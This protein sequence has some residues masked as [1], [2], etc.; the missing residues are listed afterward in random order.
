MNTKKITTALIT[1]ATSASL[2]AGVAIVPTTYAD[3]TSTANTAGLKSGANAAARLAKI[4]ARS[5]TAITARIAD[6]NK[7]NT[8]VQGLKNVSSTE[9]T[10]ISNDVQTNISG[11]TSL[12]AKI[13]AD[14]DATAA[15]NDEKTITG[16]FRIYA[17]V[18]PQGSILA[19]V[20]RVNTIVD[21]MTPI[22][23]KI[24]SRITA[25]QTAGKDVSALQTLLS[26][27]NS[28]IADAKIQAVAAQSGVVSLVP[29]QGNKTTLAS[30]TA[31]LKAARANI[32]TAT[33]DLQTARQD[34]K[35][36]T[37]SLKTM[38]KQSSTSSSA[39]STVSQ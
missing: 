32:K 14:T 17:L 3:S 23:S 29:D 21:L 31:A 22:G 34:A 33:N 38:D 28:K 30:N 10:N 13:D 36:I 19:S 27:F 18:V 26:D 37:Q 8:R 4:I 39:S 9:K 15:L 25:D 20:D 12:K 16:S 35:K 2:L 7:L 5:D 6:L 1:I 24:Q 11:L